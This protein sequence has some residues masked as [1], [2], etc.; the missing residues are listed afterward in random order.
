MHEELEPLAGANRW[1]ANAVDEAV[2][3]LVKRHWPITK[4]NTMKT[5]PTH[6][7]SSR[8][9]AFETVREHPIGYGVGAALLLTVA[10]VTVSCIP[11]LVRYM[12][13]RNM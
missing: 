9:R 12:R 6:R 1:T 8:P 11:D 5:E 3:S 13:I 2:E 7:E 4:G 10:V